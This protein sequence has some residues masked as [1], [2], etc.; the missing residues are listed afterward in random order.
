MTVRQRDSFIRC[1]ILSLT[2]ILMLVPGLHAQIV[3]AGGLT[4]ERTAAAGQRYDG[5]IML[6]N[7]G[8]AVQ[9]ARLYLT[10]Y[11]FT[12]DGRSF[13]EPPGTNPRSS[14]AWLEMANEYVTIPP[15]QQMI[16]DYTVHVPEDDSLAGTYWCLL[17]VEAV[18]PIEPQAEVKSGM[19]IRTKIRYGIQIVTQIGGSGRG[20][21]IFHKPDLIRQESGTALQVDLENIGE[22]MLR[23]EVWLEL[24]DEK[25]AKLGPFTDRIMRTY[26]NTSVRYRLDLSEVGPGSYKAVMI[27]DCGEDDLFGVNFTLQIER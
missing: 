6:R 1:L 2:V 22:K 18:P 5:E 21:L 4:H 10:D 9:E 3:V 7:E 19:A 26:P 12:S 17:M 13:Y 14:A 23:P 24:Y 25:G 20:E 11:R 27:A 8:E 16:V 15:R